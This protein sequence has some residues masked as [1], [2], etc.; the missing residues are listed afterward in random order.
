MQTARF[1]Q[2]LASPRTVVMGVLNVTPDSFSDGGLF[3]SAEKATTHAL[4]M[5]DDGADIIDIGGQSTRPPGS[6]YG[7]GAERITTDEELRRILPVIDFLMMERPDCIISIDTSRAEV[8]KRAIES[9]ATII[10]DVSAGTDDPEMFSVAKEAS[11]P[12]VLMHGYGPEFQK[13]SIDEYHYEDV[14]FEVL[15][16]LEQRITAARGAG[17]ETILADIG[18][19]F[20]KG[21][22]DNIKLLKEHA[23]FN[24]LQVPM[25]L[26]VSRKSTIGKILG[27]V[28]PQERVNGSIAA[29]CYGARNGAKI[30]RTHDIRQTKEAL[31][32]I[33]VLKAL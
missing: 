27:G 28:P 22:T 31:Q 9:G 6:T 30:I 11:V 26:G 1:T 32:V 20:A 16:W 7:T 4:A 5:L 19:G 21:A 14:V 10:N 15:T 33:D 29:S 25:V 23:A 24:N 3:H 2:L 17:I 13:T 8:A 12:I 18:F